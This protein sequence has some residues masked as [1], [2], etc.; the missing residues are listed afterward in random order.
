VGS[1]ALGEARPLKVR[2][3]FGLPLPERHMAELATYIAACAQAAPGFRWVASPN[4]HLTARFIGSIE[5]A[6]AEMIAERLTAVPPQAFELQLGGTG[7]FGR[8]RRARVVWLGL[9]L[10]APELERLAARVEAECVGA[11][12]APE[13]R[14]LHPHLTLARALDRDGAAL[15]DLPEAP[16]LPPWPARE[17]ILYRSH[18]GRTGSTYEALR[19]IRLA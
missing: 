9:L 15:P 19:T 3:F 17:L 5:L 7:R 6:N 16:L 14:P 4:L 11:G 2:A 18:L 8:G 13:A 10:G 12:L 1:F